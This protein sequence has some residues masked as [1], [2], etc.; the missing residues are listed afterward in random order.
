[1]TNTLLTK[2]TE[3]SLHEY[4]GVAYAERAVRARDNATGVAVQYQKQPDEDEAETDFLV[5]ERIFGI[6]TNA[7]DD[8]FSG[9]FCEHVDDEPANEETQ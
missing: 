8:P 6:Y 2:G 1:M 5:G 7:I 3:G 9:A 4:N